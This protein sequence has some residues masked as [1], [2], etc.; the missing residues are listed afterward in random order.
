MG[1][2]DRHS[3]IN[4]LAIVLSSRIKKEG[5]SPLTLDFGEIQGNGSLLTNTFPIPIPKGDYS[6]CRQATGHPL[7]AGRRV[8]VAWVQNEAVVIGTIEKS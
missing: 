7:D 5:V 8:L 2:F 1:G 6:V 3:G 4:R